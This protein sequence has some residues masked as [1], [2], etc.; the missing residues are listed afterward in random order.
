LEALGLKT[1]KMRVIR[2][3]GIGQQNSDTKTNEFFSIFSDLADGRTKLPAQ[4]GGFSFW[5]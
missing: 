4:N 3:S 5:H 1:V 2:I